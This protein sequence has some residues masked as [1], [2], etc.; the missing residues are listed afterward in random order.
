[1]R[2]ELANFLPLLSE[3]ALP[4]VPEAERLYRSGDAGGRDQDQLDDDFSLM[5][6]T[7]P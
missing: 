7:L 4:G 3:P 2:W 5:V 6:V 1:M